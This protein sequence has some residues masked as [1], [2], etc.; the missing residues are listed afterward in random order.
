MS[1]LN[2]GDSFPEGVSFTYIPYA[3]ETKDVTACGVP[4]KY[5][6]SKEFRN[7]K[8][9]LVAVPGAFTP[10]CQEQ[11][12]AS[13]IQNVEKLKAKGVDQVIFISVNDHWVMSAWGKAN[14]VTG[15]Y[16][17]FASDGGLEFSKSLGWTNGDRPARYA[18][19]V[20]HGKV[21]HAEKDVPKSIAA[22]GA[23]GILAKL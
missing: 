6:A 12:I 14:S 22:S 16:M 17:I 13:Y 23:E 19:I 1:T 10:I 3:P 18:I 5:D 8:V 2:A 21:I 9:V 7:K 4:V 15:E 20:D 11:H